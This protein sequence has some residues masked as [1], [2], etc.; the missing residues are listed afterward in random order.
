[1]PVRRRDRVN[2]ELIAARLCPNTLP[3]EAGTSAALRYTFNGARW[4]TMC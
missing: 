2:T 3:Y 4:A 1:M